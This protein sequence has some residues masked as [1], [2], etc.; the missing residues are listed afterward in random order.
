MIEPFDISYIITGTLIPVEIPALKEWAHLILAEKM[1]V[2][3]LRV[4]NIHLDYD[5]ANIFVSA[6]LLDRTSF[7]GIIMCHNKNNNIV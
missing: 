3:I 2:S 6:T 5:D 4:T 1:D 7:T